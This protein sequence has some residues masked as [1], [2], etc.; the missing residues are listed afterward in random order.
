MTR[1]LFVCLGNICRSPAAEA[2]FRHLAAD[3]GWDDRLEI[4]SA[5]TGA[6][7]A[8]EP[9]D[10]RMRAAARRRGIEVASIA[11]QVARED[12]ARF[13]HIFAMDADNLEALHQ[14]APREHR[15]KIRLFRDLDPDEPG[16]DVPDPYY[17]GPEGFDEVL[18]IVTRAS[19]ALLDELSDASR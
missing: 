19:R 6:W 15:E 12:F 5:G 2:V 17:G 3:A 7:H 8:G 13:D 9:A 16:A 11:R 1:V 14:L 4:D 10:R 18:D